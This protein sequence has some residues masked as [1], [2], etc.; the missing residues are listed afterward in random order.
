MTKSSD[1]VSESASGP[2]PDGDDHKHEHGEEAGYVHE[3][4]TYADSQTVQLAVPKINWPTMRT[5]ASNS[6]KKRDRINDSHRHLVRLDMTTESD[7][8]GC[9]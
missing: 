5:K 3:D 4:T 9:Y 1:R 6:L 8:I 7:G 2:R